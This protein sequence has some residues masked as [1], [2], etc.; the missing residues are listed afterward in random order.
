MSLIQAASCVHAAVMWAGS[1]WSCRAH[2]E[3]GILLQC[4]TPITAI[5]YGTHQG[6]RSYM[7][8]AVRYTAHCG[9]S[10]LD[11]QQGVPVL[12]SVKP[13]QQDPTTRQTPSGRWPQ[14]AWRTMGEKLPMQS[15][16]RRPLTPR[17]SAPACAAAA[18]HSPA[19]HSACRE[20]LGPDHDN[21]SLRQTCFAWPAAFEC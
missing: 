10:R 4:Y 2:L 11:G 1:P 16:S 20:V 17:A 21:P 12:L 13:L 9:H 6:R 5:M 8:V 15:S 3:A 18:A 7:C 19:V 14:R